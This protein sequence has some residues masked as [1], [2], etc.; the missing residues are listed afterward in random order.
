MELK[1]KDIVDTYER[2]IGKEVKIVP[3]PGFPNE[4]LVEN[5]GDPIDI[6]MYRSLVGK[7]MFVA[8]KVLPA[9][10]N[11]SRELA[12]H[13]S[14]PGEEHWHAIGRCVGYLKGT[15]L[16]GIILTQPAE[17][18][19]ADLC[20]ANYAQCSDTRRSAGGTL[21]TLGGMITH[22]T[23]K[24]QATVS[25][26]ST[27]SEYHSL[28]ECCKET[29]FTQQLCQEAAYIEVPGVVLEDNNGAIFLSKNK[30]VGQRTEHIDIKHHFVVR[31]FCS[32]QNGIQQ[33]GVIVKV[34]TELN[35]SDIMTKSPDVKTF[36][37]HADE[38]EAGLPWIKAH[39]FGIDGVITKHVGGMSRN[40]FHIEKSLSEKE[41]Q[42][43]PVGSKSGSS[44]YDGM[45]S[46]EEVIINKAGL[47]AS[48][49]RPA[50]KK[51]PSNHIPS[52]GV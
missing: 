29:T 35:H 50:L 44:M 48:K 47:P 46:T 25:L 14:N 34:P 3:S 40:V 27:E 21:Y 45:Q 19:T 33:R 18:R 15:S 36:K 49:K 8:T 24:K 10:V 6:D 39:V 38:I 42:G 22:F 23:S 20:D 11:T 31:E 9:V 28:V 17:L 5:E 52:F 2:Y 30:Q 26:S 4:V 37:Y 7:I 32:E 12:G 1:V 41:F 13:M 43:S 16:K 51:R